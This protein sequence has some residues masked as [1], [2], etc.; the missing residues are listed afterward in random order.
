MPS[1]TPHAGV[2][3]DLDLSPA[4]PGA[5]YCEDFPLLDELDIERDRGAD[6]VVQTRHVYAW[7]APRSPGDACTV[8]TVSVDGAIMLERGTIVASGVCVMRDRYPWSQ[9]TWCCVS[10]ITGLPVA[11]GPSRR[12]AV[13][14]YWDL[15][16]QYPPGGWLAAH[17]LMSAARRLGRAPLGGEIQA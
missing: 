17:V 10:T 8:R 2:Y 1:Y 3:V 4:E 9:S 7:I 6:P 11:R 16:R 14:G 13:V 5:D 12:D 15:A